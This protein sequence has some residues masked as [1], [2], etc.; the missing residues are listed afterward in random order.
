MIEIRIIFFILGTFFGIDNSNI[1]SESV[2]VEIDPESKTVIVY[3]KG[4]YTFIKDEEEIIIVLQELEILRNLNQVIHTEEIQSNGQDTY[5]W[6]EL[7]LM[8]NKDDEKLDA[9]LQL[10]Y[11]DDEFLESMGISYSVKDKAY[12]MINFESDNIQSSVGE[13]NGNRW[14][15]KEKLI[16]TIEPFEIEPNI[17]VVKKENLFQY[18]EKVKP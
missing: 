14:Y 4:L 11:K 9:K 7:E 8:S 16:F 17:E 15:F 6:I 2:Q 10:K 12:T 3:H 5:D 18:W 1:L 13:L